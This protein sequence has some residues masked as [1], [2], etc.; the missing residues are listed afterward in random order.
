VKV[1]ELKVSDAISGQTTLTL[2][3]HTAGVLSV[4]FSPDGRRIISGGIDRTVKVWDVATGQEML[5]LTGNTDRVSR[6]AFSPDGRW[7]ASGNEGFGD[8]AVNI[9]DAGPQEALAEV[10]FGENPTK[11]IGKDAT[12]SRAKLPQG[13][14]KAV[15]GTVGLSALPSDSRQPLDSP[16]KRDDTG[17]PCD[18]MM[19]RI[20]P[21]GS[22]YQAR[23]TAYAEKNDLDKAIADYGEAIRLDPTNARL[24]ELRGVAHASRK[25][26]FA[27]AIADFSE[28]IRLNP[29]SGSEYSA[30]GKLYF[31]N[32]DMEKAISNL[33][34]AVA[35][36]PGNPSFWYERA[37]ILLAMGRPEENRKDCAEM[38]QFFGQ[39]A[40]PDIAHCVAWTCALASNAVGDLSQA[41]ALAEKAAKSHP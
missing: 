29:N 8:S 10:S 20:R 35:R 11:D 28:V 25:G 19:I 16:V 27:M 15:G 1:S 3:G 33:S 18:R 32:G 22:F 37:L 6:V 17:I 26:D 9:W 36:E 13:I 14:E 34:T 39:T 40:P 2:K 24:Y 31:K 5:T 23:G 38:L 41:V 30:R 7:I 21:D 4:A 12:T